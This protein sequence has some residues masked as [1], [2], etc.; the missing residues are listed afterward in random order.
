MQARVDAEGS[1]GQDGAEGGRCALAGG[2]CCALGASYFVA[3]HPSAVLLREGL[4]CLWSI[5]LTAP[6]CRCPGDR[7]QGPVSPRAKEPCQAQRLEKQKEEEQRGKSQR[8]MERGQ[9]GRR[10]GGRARP[11]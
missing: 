1:W 11:L 9:M 6:E 3:S 7:P 8:W 10:A 4:I 5:C 2:G